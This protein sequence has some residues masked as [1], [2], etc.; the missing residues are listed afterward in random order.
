VEYVPFNME[1]AAIMDE[2]CEDSHGASMT[3]PTGDAIVSTI[4]R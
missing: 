3:V 1:K 2:S 4:G